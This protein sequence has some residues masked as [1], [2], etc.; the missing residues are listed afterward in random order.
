MSPNDF[1]KELAPGAV[2][3]MKECGICA[4]FTIAQAALE[5]EWACS[6]LTKLANNLF[7][8]KSSAAWQGATLDM[9]TK[10][11]LMREL[12]KMRQTVTSEEIEFTQRVLTGRDNAA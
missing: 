9:H 12:E 7:G 3:S 6:D 5:S 2:A 11:H 4:S 8:V 10:E 1:I